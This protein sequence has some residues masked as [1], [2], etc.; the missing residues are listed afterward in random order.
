MDDVKL[1]GKIAASG[2]KVQA[3]RLRV[4]SENLANADSVA[5][6][7]GEDPYQRKTITFKNVMDRELGTQVV[8]VDKVG[9]D[10]SEFQRRYDPNH[11]GAGEDGY[12]LMPNVNPLVELMDMR[13]AQ[14][15]YEAN[16]DVIGVS[17][18]M[19]KKTLDLLR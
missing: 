13:E 16:L 12:V 14:R 9:V 7:P 4:I 5:A 15:T 18:E 3:Q 6:R 1:A 8:E 2:M 19:V 10:R 11:P 17:K